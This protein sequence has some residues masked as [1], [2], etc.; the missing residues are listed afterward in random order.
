MKVFVLGLDGATWDL[1]RPLAEAG[2][3]PNLARLMAGGAYRDA[4]IGLSAAQPG[5]L[6]RGHDRQELGQA[7]RLRVPR[8]RAQPAGRPGQLVAG[9]QGRAGLGDR[10]A[11]RQDDGGR[12]RADELSATA[13]RPGFYLGDFLSPADAPDF[14]SDPALLA[15]LEA[16]LGGPYRPWST[17]VHDGGNEAEALAEL[18]DFLDHHLKAVSFLHERGA[19]GTSSCST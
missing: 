13:R 8:A 19:T 6:D 17:A 11:A 1:L 2:D 9:D 3:L 16:E 12:R 15:E 4:R 14:A 7:R 10:R 18:T 5:R